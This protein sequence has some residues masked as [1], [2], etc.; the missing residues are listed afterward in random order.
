MTRTV[1][2]W[3]DCLLVRSL[4][5]PS[6]RMLEIKQR[7]VQHPKRIAGR[8]RVNLAQLRIPDRT[9]CNQVFWRG[10]LPFDLLPEGTSLHLPDTE[11]ELP[12]S[13]SICA[14]SQQLLL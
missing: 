11:I 14:A 8:I 2:Q 10:I 7:S 4:R 5:S 3:R 12:K 1:P 13:E 9:F 6:H